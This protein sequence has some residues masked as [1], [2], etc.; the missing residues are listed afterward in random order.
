MKQR[1]TD[2]EAAHTCPICGRS[3]KRN[4]FC[5]SCF[6]KVEKQFPGGEWEYM[7]IEEIRAALENPAEERRRRAGETVWTEG[8]PEQDG[9]STGKRNGRS[10]KQDC[11]CCGMTIR[12]GDPLAADI[13]QGGRVCGECAS[14]VRVLYPMDYTWAIVTYDDD[15]EY[16]TDET[17]LRLDPLKELDRAGFAA[18]MEAA[19][20][21]RGSRRRLYGG[22]AAYFR[23]D[24]NARI[25]KDQGK[26]RKFI[27]DEYA[28]S[29]TV[30][31]GE[32]KTPCR[33]SVRRREGGYSFPVK[34]LETPVSNHLRATEPA[35]R[36]REGCPG[37][38][39][40][41]EDA[42]CIYPGDIL[43]AE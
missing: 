16:D 40:L 7:E 9:G 20:T 14:K 39:I 6:E 17:T 37:V 4:G 33:V 42:A 24:D 43:A 15:Y 12:N 41:G 35:K 29:G 28:I 11:A 13:A 34:R 30:V 26:G 25:V 1:T 2:S 27:T 38:L 10:G 19:E 22:G 23:V 8:G 32:V 18:A 31:L 36:I 5:D 3:M 21:E